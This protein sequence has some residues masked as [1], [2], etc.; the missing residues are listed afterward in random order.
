MA[1]GGSSNDIEITVKVDDKGAIQTFDKLGNKIDE[2]EEKASST[3]TALDR[4][5]G[6]IGKI[7]SNV[8]G[9]GIGF[10]NFGGT[11]LTVNQGLELASKAFDLAGAAISGAIDGINR[12][13][14]VDD[15]AASFEN[16]AAAAGATSETLLTD[17][18]NA[19]GNTISK[20]DLM[21]QSNELLL[22]GIDPSKFELL[23]K[24]ARSLAEVT[25]GDAAQ[26]LDKLGDSLLRGNTRA[27]KSLGI[28]I[29]NEKAVRDYAA[30]SGLLADQLTDEQKAFALRDATL[31]SLEENQAKLGDVTD[32]AADRINQ[33]S[34]V[35][36]DGA[37]EILRAVANNKDLNDALA[38]L[39]SV[40]SQVDFTAIANGLSEIIGL[41]ARAATA[42]IETGR[43]IAEA[44]NTNSPQEAFDARA[45]SIDDFTKKFES[46]KTAIGD[47]GSQDQLLKLAGNFTKLQDAIGKVGDPKL[48]S[49][50]NDTFFS[51]NQLANEAMAKLPKAMAAGGSAAKGYEKA[52]EG[53]NQAL[54][55][56]TASKAF[57]EF[58]KQIES[59]FA[60]DAGKKGGKELQDAIKKIGEAAQ[61]AGV[62]AEAFK[63]IIDDTI[64]SYKKGS[65]TASAVSK[66]NADDLKK[67]S[68]AIT[69]AT[70][71]DKFPLLTKQIEEAFAR[72]SVIGAEGVAK[73]LEEIGKAALKANIPVEE[74]AKHIQDVGKLPT[75]GPGNT[76]GLKEFQD[77]TAKFL[78]SQKAFGDSLQSSMASA[79]GDAL[80]G[81]VN[82]TLNRA[83]LKASIQSLGASMGSDLGMAVGGP[84]GA[85]FGQALGSIY[86]KY[87]SKIADIGKSAKGSQS[88]TTAL[89]DLMF[90][91]IGTAI[92]SLVGDSLFGGDSAGTEARKAADKF[93]ADAFDAQRLSVIIDGQIQ[94]I[95]DLVFQGNTLFG[96]DVS[97]GD[98]SA[99]NFLQGLEPAAQAAFSGIGAAFEALLGTSTEASGQIA[100]ALANNIGGS[101]NNLQLLVQ[102]SGV[103]FDQLKTSVVDAFLNGEL[104][105][106]EAAN[107]LT[108]VANISQQGIPDGLGM[109]AEAFHNLT[110]ASVKD[111]RVLVD[112]L[113]DIG[114]EA[115]ELG[116]K[117]FGSLRQHLINAG[118]SATDVDKLLTSLTSN[119]I[120]NVEELASATAEQL[121]PALGALQN[122]K[123]PFNEALSE[124]NSKA[125]D[126]IKT[127]NELPDRI[128]KTIAF[129]VELNDPNNALGQAA[130][131]SG[132]STRSITAATPQGRG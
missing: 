9:A 106:N 131:V 38:G 47:A 109:I 22:G 88:G 77:E 74:I 58:A 115:R 27:L 65:E 79:L 101:L 45:K 6:Q 116:I 80:T 59:V 85:A 31:K 87:A 69:D 108:Q 37:D 34:K 70:D 46:L 33:F 63:A 16:L 11:N 71:V 12:G 26:G 117:D 99:F 90:P 25:G 41:L 66:K 1:I 123:F 129:N 132:V 94:Q 107:A 89:V 93:F 8:L 67:L 42:A 61:K 54:T 130:A 24:A 10:Q 96:G 4:L 111:G 52:L 100:A 104:A 49:Q 119:G 36:G 51:I 128:E 21:R 105:A 78:A 122:V 126:L 84:F 76:E 83:D 113:G 14:E 28:I 55:K 112:A 102:A 73:A 124:A 127:V 40:I 17:L 7:T 62:P 72:E 15:I 97:F 23:G 20:T 103:S 2:T 98:G 125:S 64:S 91:G 35:L 53:V 30:A 120:D 60:S 3:G 13:S 121:I 50:L 86:G 75:F 48:R 39:V 43:A 32:D 114:A 68:A 82:G 44:F 81:A 57:P 95:K 19:L 110:S 5:T 118:I 92:N 29:D 56:A 18:D